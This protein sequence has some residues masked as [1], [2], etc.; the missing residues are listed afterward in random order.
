VIIYLL[1]C[2]T[3]GKSYVGQ[4]IDPLDIRWGEHC[5]CALKG[6]TLLYRAIRKYGLDAFDRRVLEECD[7]AA[8]DERE[9][10][11]IAELKT[12]KPGGYNMTEGGQG[13]RGHQHTEETKQHLSQVLRGRQFTKE[14]RQNLSRAHTG[15]RHTPETK[16]KCSLAAK[17]AV[18]T[19]ERRRK[20]AEAN[21]RRVISDETRKRMSEAQ[22]KR[23]D[24]TRV[25]SSS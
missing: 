18:Y 1:T 6:Q 24:K 21:R 2:R 20:V 22:R 16:Q 8:L 10:H 7:E 5:G 14:H 9:R 15:R 23:Y 4:T 25:A 3:S 12:L 13:T 19:D 17:S 11:W